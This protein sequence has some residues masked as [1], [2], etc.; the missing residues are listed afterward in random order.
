MLFRSQVLLALWE[1]SHEIKVEQPAKKSK[2]G[3]FSR[4]KD[5]DDEDDDE[6]EEV[7][8]ALI[9]P[10]HQVADLIIS[11]DAKPVVKGKAKTVPKVRLT[12]VVKV[13]GSGS[14]SAVQLVDGAVE[15][16][17]EF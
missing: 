3:F 17:T 7:R 6:P 10:E 4:S 2:G 16:T 13:G 14:V 11:V 12:L 8:T 5:D 15:T 1:G 9:K